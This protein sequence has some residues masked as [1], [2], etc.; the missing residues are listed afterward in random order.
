MARAR[1][2]VW[3]ENKD[4]RRR[5]QGRGRRKNGVGQSPWPMPSSCHSV[6]GLTIL[7]AGPIQLDDIGVVDLLQEVEF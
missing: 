2:H 5:G 6:A 3:T 7:A 1:D 4:Q